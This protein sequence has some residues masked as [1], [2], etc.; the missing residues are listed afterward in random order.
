M[1]D[2]R[3]ITGCQFASDPELPTVEVN[4]L[5]LLTILYCDHDITAENGAGAGFA[6]LVIV[7]RTGHR[8]RFK[9]SLIADVKKKSFQTT[10]NVPTIIKYDDSWLSQASSFGTVDRQSA[11]VTN[12]LTIACVAIPKEPTVITRFYEMHHRFVS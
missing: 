2:D 11:N 9:K 12:I 8:F 10:L 7:N 4:A 5:S 1:S 6:F 3:F